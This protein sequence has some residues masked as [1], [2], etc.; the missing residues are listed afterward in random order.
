MTP[1]IS[2]IMP[3]YNV[4]AYIGEAIT[5][6]LKQS[7]VHW[8]LIVVNDGSMDN[9]LEI[10]SSFFDPR[11]HLFNQKNGGVGK[12]R[13]YALQQIKG[14]YFCFL[15]AD[16]ILP[17][18]AL[19]ARL[20]IFDKDPNIAFVSGRV[21]QVNSDLSQVLL[22]QT[23][24]FRGLPQKEII[25]LNP[26]CLVTIN[27]LIK[28][29]KNKNY[30]FPEGWTHSE[31]VA[32]FLSISEDG[33]YDF[34]EEEVLIY[35][36]NNNSAMSNLDGLKDGYVKY[37]EF[38]LDTVVNLEDKDRIYLKNRIRRIMVLSYLHNKQFLRALKS[39]WELSRL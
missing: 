14:D 4:E 8:E 13:N 29:K 15:D 21:R 18:N 10:A 3:A 39:F 23:P 20:E 35:R 19:K 30:S 25:R 32:F 31:D 34:T 38:V 5:S 22:I 6:V 17:E 33:L 27:W 36:R 1:L 12:A 2:I 28:R 11:I 16:D 26:S 37:Y 7:Y 24:T 9:T